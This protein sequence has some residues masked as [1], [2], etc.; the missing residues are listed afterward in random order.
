MITLPAVDWETCWLHSHQVALSVLFTLPFWR[1]ILFSSVQSLSHV[2]VIVTP[3]TAARQAFLSMTNSWSLL[4]LMSIESVM[5]SNCLIL[6][7][8]YGLLMARGVIEFQL[9]YFKSW[10][11]ILLKCCTQYASQLWKTQQWLQ[12][13]KR[14]VFIPR[15]K[16]VQTTT[17][18]HSFYMLAK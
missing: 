11:M 1:G 14:S 3:W 18:L 9:S 12:D 7:P 6:C 13:W 17:Q 2:R 10:K 4:K 15:P 8:F 5:P 16:N